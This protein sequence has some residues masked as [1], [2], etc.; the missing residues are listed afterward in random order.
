MKSSAVRLIRF[1]DRNLTVAAH[2]AS[3]AGLHATHEGMRVNFMLGSII[4]VRRLLC[5]FVLLFAVAHHQHQEKSEKR[6][7]SLVDIV[8][9]ARLDSGGLHPEN[10][11]ICSLTGQERISTESFPVATSLRDA[12][13]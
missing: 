4:N 3:H 8:L 11:L 13:K 2:D 12:A 9:G 5:T 10:S 1:E 6:S 7:H